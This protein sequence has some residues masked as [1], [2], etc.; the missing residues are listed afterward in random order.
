[1]T[2]S[3]HPYDK[4]RRLDEHFQ[5]LA[6]TDGQQAGNCSFCA[7]LT[8][9]F[10]ITRLAIVRAMAINPMIVKLPFNCDDQE[11]DPLVAADLGKIEDY[12]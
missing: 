4:A 1:M 2:E 6:D 9:R 10:N 8:C 7:A 3:P 5:N 12:E 11:D